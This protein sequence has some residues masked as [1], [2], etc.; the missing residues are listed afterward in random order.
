MCGAVSGKSR[1]KQLLLSHLRRFRLHTVENIH[2]IFWRKWT[3]WSVGED[4]GGGG[5]PYFLKSCLRLEPTSPLLAKVGQVCQL[6]NNFNFAYQHRENQHR[7]ISISLIWPYSIRLASSA[8]ICTSTS[9]K[10]TP[11]YQ[12]ITNLARFYPVGQLSTI[13]HI[14]MKEQH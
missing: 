4:G 2:E 12:F 8:I 6:S 5:D 1:Q 9:R 14:D 3:F 13:L 11:I 7:F 10:S